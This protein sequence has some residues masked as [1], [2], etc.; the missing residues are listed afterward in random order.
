[1]TAVD[2]GANIG[3][4]T[5]ALASRIG[6]GGSVQAFEPDPVNLRLLEENIAINE[7]QGRVTISGKA[8]SDVNGTVLLD[9]SHDAASSHLSRTGTQ[10]E[11]VRLD[12]YPLEALHL[13]KIDVEGTECRVLRGAAR[14]LTRF[15]PILLVECAE[16]HL[17]RANASLQELDRAL[18]DL[19]YTYRDA[20][21]AP[22][23][24]LPTNAN[25]LCTP[26]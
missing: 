6:P 19:G 18:R 13:M 24:H 3:L 20:S 2:V 25:V 17:L 8:L 23:D 12:D 9:P 14:T 16:R 21:G 15:R 5:L 26:D 1:M 11:T 7:L 4:F 10:V 22:L